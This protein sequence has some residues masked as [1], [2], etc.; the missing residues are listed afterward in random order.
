MFLSSC[1][2]ATP[3]HDYT[4]S[5]PP[6]VIIDQC[7][8]TG[9]FEGFPRLLH[10][11][12]G[13]DPP[14]N[15]GRQYTTHRSTA[16]PRASSLVPPVKEFRDIRPPLLQWRMLKLPMALA[17]LPWN[18]Y[19]IPFICACMVVWGCHANWYPYWPPPPPA[20]L[21]KYFSPLPWNT[22]P[23]PLQTTHPHRRRLDLT[24]WWSTKVLWHL[25]NPN[26]NPKP[27]TRA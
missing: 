2:S 27:N 20:T 10:P 13:G 5:T 24:Y 19:F 18:P 9:F 6:G 11:W 3:P 7:H 14:L 25:C 4:K 1:L 17:P 16:P 22:A 8:S 23:T 26:R 21:P 15:L 12:G